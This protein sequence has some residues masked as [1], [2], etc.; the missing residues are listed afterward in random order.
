MALNS[1]SLWNSQGLLAVGILY[2]IY[3]KQKSP[4][5]MLRLRP[6][7]PCYPYCGLRGG[8][9]LLLFY[10]CSWSN[11]LPVW[12]CV[13]CARSSIALTTDALASLIAL[14]TAAVSF[15]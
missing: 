12:P 13:A 8:D 11:Y 2:Q 9:I 1:I 5:K 4:S 14:E 10:F 6:L 7:P 3:S 15:D